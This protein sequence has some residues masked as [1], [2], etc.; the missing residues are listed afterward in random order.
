MSALHEY[1]HTRSLPPAQD[2][3]KENISF[4]LE[5]LIPAQGAHLSLLPTQIHTA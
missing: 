4:H 5:V 3:Y 2:T 1:L